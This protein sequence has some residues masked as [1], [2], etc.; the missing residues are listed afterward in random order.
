MLSEL[1]EFMRS[2]RFAVEASCAPGGAAQA[3]LVGVAVTDA[4]EIVFDTVD[5][6]RKARNLRASPRAAFVLGGWTTGDERTV[7]FEGIA[8]EPAGAELERVKQAYF[9]VWPDGP[10][11][12]LWPG[13]TY[14]RVRPTWIRFSNFNHAPPQIVEF[15]VDQLGAP[16]IW[17]SQA[18]TG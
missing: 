8:D 9:A 12:A 16:T 11:R 14:F 18:A 1:L 6:T 2:Q 10:S 3:A 15:T 4:F 5:T 13:L 7:Q 17:E